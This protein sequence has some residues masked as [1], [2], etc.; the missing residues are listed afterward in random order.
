MLDGMKLIRLLFCRLTLCALVG[1]FSLPLA[2]QDSVEVDSPAPGA[3]REIYKTIGETE[4]AL[5]VF[6]PEGH[7]PTD[8]RP[9]A[10]LFFGGG[11]SGGTPA[12]FAPHCK[13]LASRGMI[14]IVA[15]YRV[16]SR[17]QATPF[18]CV[19]DAKSAVRWVRKHAGRLG[20][21]PAKLAVGGGSAG[22]HVAAATA[23][24]VG[25]NE[26]DEDT[27]INAV[28][29]ALLLFNPVYDNGPGGYGHK[30][31][32]DRFREISPMHNIRNGMPPATVFLGTNDTL[33]PVATAQAF[34]KKMQA[35]GSRSE[36]HLY[37]G[38]P[39]GFF[40]HPDFKANA[41]PRYFYETMLA[42]DQFLQ[43][44]GFLKGMATLTAPSFDLDL[45]K[46]D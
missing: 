36:L 25:I 29:N 28:P 21:D 33:I 5:Y 4:L 32:G 2:A 18:D 7:Q 10:L 44:L 14:G 23:T 35:V 30:L 43:S 42:T 6:E 16:K 45:K 38:Q 3:R 46:G 8:Q 26:D 9:A 34:Q 20:I 41:S 24:I 1:Y 17:Q 31:F 27:T 22:G 19:K 37:D 13:Y 39:H 40:N 15:D 11:W 12:Q